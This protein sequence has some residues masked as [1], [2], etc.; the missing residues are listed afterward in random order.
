MCIRCGK[1]HQHSMSKQWST[2]LKHRLSWT[3]K[4]PISWFVESRPLSKILTTSCSVMATY[5][6]KTEL[7]T[8]LQRGS[9]LRLVVYEGDNS[10]SIIEAD[11]TAIQKSEVAVQSIR[12]ISDENGS[13]GIQR[14]FNSPAYWRFTLTSTNGNQR[15]TW[16]KVGEHSSL[17]ATIENYQVDWIVG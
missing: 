4:E 2:I 8:F 11:N 16:W 13:G 6:S 3:G 14:R 17:P 1:L 9:P 10:Y 5:G 15:T 7:I 12:Y